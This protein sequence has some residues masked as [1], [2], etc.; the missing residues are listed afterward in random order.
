M[1]AGIPSPRMSP[2]VDD[3]VARS[4]GRYDVEFLQILVA[5]VASEFEG[6][7]VRDYVE[8]LIAKQVAD[9]LRRLDVLHQATT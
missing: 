1:N 9:E 4:N 6:A 3:L 5:N 2:I 7:R 8:V